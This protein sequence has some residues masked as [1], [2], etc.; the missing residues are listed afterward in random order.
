VYIHYGNHREVHSVCTYIMGTIGRSIQC[1]HY[2]NH[3][4]VH[5]VCA[6]I[7][8]TIG[9]YIQCVHTLWDPIVF[10]YKHNNHET[11][12]LKI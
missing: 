8:G 12:L 4:E 10:T 2:G 3:R 9:K 6:Y 11:F 7:V 5:S 1:V